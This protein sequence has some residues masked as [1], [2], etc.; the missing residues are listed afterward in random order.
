MKKRNDAEKLN[1]EFHKTEQGGRKLRTDTSWG[2]PHDG[3]VNVA[4]K[5]DFRVKLILVPK[6]FWTA[7]LVFSSLTLATSF[8]KAPVRMNLKTFCT[9]TISDLFNSILWTRWT[10]S[11]NFKLDQ[12][13]KD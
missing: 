4:Q 10:P 12:S 13:I 6:T 5:A 1:E 2:V 3:M 9:K 11:S 7:C 8:L